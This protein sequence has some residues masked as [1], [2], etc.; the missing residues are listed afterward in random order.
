MKKKETPIAEAEKQYEKHEYYLARRATQKI[1]EKE[2]DNVAAQR[3]MGKILD[4]EVER[5]RE[6]LIPQAVEEMNADEK[7]TEVK[8]WLERSRALFG[9]NDYDLALF[10]AEKVFI[11]DPDNRQASELIDEIK[12]KAIKEGKADVLFLNKMY[13][14]EIADRL[15]K[16]R[17]QA[18]G[19]A[20][21]G[22]Y[23]QARFTVEKILLLEPDDPKALRLYQKIL[24]QEEV[25]RH[26]A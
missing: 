11:Y 12:E 17:D 5:Q 15:E 4:A 22:Y 16:Y 24:E 19:L 7:S 23:G 1:L 13:K 9:R 8:T 26:E 21:E 18:K 3:L 6:Q 20:G 14:E 25:K 10:A 2:P